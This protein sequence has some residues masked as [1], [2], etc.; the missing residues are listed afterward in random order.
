MIVPVGSHPTSF[1]VPSVAPPAAL[2]FHLIGQRNGAM[3][4][5]LKSLAFLQF[6]FPYPRLRLIFLE[7]NLAL[8]KWNDGG[9]GVV[10][11][12]RFDLKTRVVTDADFGMLISSQCL[13]HNRHR[14]PYLQLLPRRLHPHRLQPPSLLRR[15]I[16]IVWKLLVRK[17]LLMSPCLDRKWNW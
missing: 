9:G 5:G 6:L 4:G 7:N 12:V 14:L 16:Q 13:T 17:Q 11:E 1:T 10:P 2:P 8:S 3:V 15:Q